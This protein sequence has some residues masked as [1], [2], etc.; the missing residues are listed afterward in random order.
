MHW[1]LTDETNKPPNEDQFFIYG[2]LLLHSDSVPAVDQIV[3]NVRREFGYGP[4]ASFK[5]S[6]GGSG[7]DAATHEAA[8]AALLDR[9][10]ETGVKFAV[11]LIHARIRG[12]QH[13]N[14]VIEQAINTLTMAYWEFLGDVDDQGVMLIDR[15]DSARGH[16]AFRDFTRRFTEG[17]DISGRVRPVNDRILLFGMTNNNSSHLSSAVDI[18]IGAFRTC[19]NASSQS[20]RD[21]AARIYWPLIDPLIW[22][23]DGRRSAGG[24]RPRPVDVRAPA[25]RRIYERLEADLRRWGA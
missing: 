21:E 7:Q 11:T 20:S 6:V 2:G 1:L 16:D 5:F 25:V 14:A 17:L 19:V 8:K 12:D 9:L 24:Y 3:R 23:R 10:T 22:R 13:I 15:V 18:C 4:S